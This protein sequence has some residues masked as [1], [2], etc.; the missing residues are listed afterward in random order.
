[1]EKGESHLV[2]NKVPESVK[3]KINMLF[4]ITLLIENTLIFL[5]AMLDSTLCSQG[6]G[7]QNRSK[8]RCKDGV[9]KWETSLR[10]IIAVS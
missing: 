5:Q 8:T 1:M 3:Q 4:H 6:C 9:V 7:S 2:Q 10:Q